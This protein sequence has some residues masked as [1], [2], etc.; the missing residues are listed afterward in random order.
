VQIDGEHLTLS[1]LY[2]VAFGNEFCSINE[3]SAKLLDERRE[4]LETNS[5]KKT[6]YGVNTGFGVMA[7][8]RI[9]PKDLDALQRNIVLSHA[10][11]VGEPLKEEHVRAVMLVR[12]NSLLKGYSGV[13]KCVVQRILDLL[14]NGIVP[15]VPA[16]GSVGA[17]GD[18]APLAHIAMTLIG[19]G[20]CLV[21]GKLVSS[22]QAL[23]SKCLEPL[24]LKAKEGLSLL[25]GTALM[26][27]LAGCSTYTASRLLDQ[28]IL[29]AA[30]SVD[31]LMGSTS[32]FDERV[33]KARPHRGQTYVA[34]KLRESLEGSEIRTSHLD[35]DRVQDAYTLRTIPQVYG[36]VNDTIEY[37]ETVLETEINSATDNPLIFENG[38]A[39]SGGNF[40]GEPV[41]LVA[42]FL[43]IALT[44]LG[45]MIER[46][47][48]R[49]VNPK[50]NDLPAFLTNGEEGLNSGYMIWQYTAAALASENKTLAHPA[51]AD[52]IPTSGFQEDHVSMG[53]WG[54][55]KLWSILDNVATLISIEALLAFR[56]LSFRHPRKS[57]SVIEQLFEEIAGIVPDHRE[58]RY[59]GTEF[60]SVRELLFKRAGL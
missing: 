31:A 55:R 24:V 14:N 42:D 21:D 59:F 26:A 10:A 49:L 23:A 35:C 38:D 51:S 46:R 33:H 58:D 32:P 50:L 60:S 39:I 13:R 11:G 27:G 48:D 40:H 16:K 20:D 44:D 17:S 22:S 2:N 1:G 25:N 56:A 47:I 9:S 15:I 8:H 5:M 19:E 52:S 6:I 34:K 7:D 3:L 29:V 53:A 4:S 36:A 28:A 45:N 54:A 12:A 43:S 18:L 37:A 57:G 41:A 30:M